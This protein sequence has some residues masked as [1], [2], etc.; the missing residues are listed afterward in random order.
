MNFGGGK[1]IFI[2]NDLNFLQKNEENNNSVELVFQSYII[3]Q[4]KNV[5][6][7]Q[8]KLFK[9]RLI[10][11]NRQTLFQKSHDLIEKYDN[12]IEYQHKKFF[13]FWKR[14]TKWKLL[15]KDIN[16]IKKEK[17]IKYILKLIIYVIMKKKN[18]NKFFL[19]IN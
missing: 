7:L 14:K 15:K 12:L 19:K 6:I 11:I 16:I 10:K 9:S 18:I 17:K 4:N 1:S 3:Q 13:L 8:W 5:L 2:N